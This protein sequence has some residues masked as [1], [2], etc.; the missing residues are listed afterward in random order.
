[1][2][3]RLLVVL[4]CLAPAATASADTSLKV[5]SFNIWGAGQHNG[6]PLDDTIAVL[7][8]S[9]A[10]VIGL[11]EVYRRGTSCV[12]QSCAEAEESLACAIARAIAF[13]C[14]EQAWEPG[15]HGVNA[16]LSRFP[17]RGAAGGGLG[18]RIDAGGREATV[19][20]IH[21]PD[22]PYQPYQLAGIPYDDA[23]FLASAA[24]A[25]RSAAAVR[26]SIIGRL[27]REVAALGDAPVVI[28][29]D[30][31]EPSHRD[32]TARAA[33]AG[34][35]PLP[36]A[37]PATRRIETMGFTD[38]YRA[39]F[40]DEIAWPGHTWTTLPAARERH[41]RIDFIFARGPGLAIASAAVVGEPS[42][43]SDI[44]VT[45]WPSDHRAVLATLRFGDAG[46]R[47]AQIRE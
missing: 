4:T 42:A 12:T 20:N 41:D 22:A 40:P 35:N 16:V 36:V 14:H 19:F 38:A 32:W 31:N 18:V 29:G 26:G 23:P 27:E 28:I 47:V 8:A 46:P 37:W 21:L 44:A 3:R 34:L 33:A 17:I 11:Q 7:R 1:M 25:E 43:E 9:G 13:H 2:L 6:R 39:V 45:P 10:D 30:F 24:E 15:L 5:L